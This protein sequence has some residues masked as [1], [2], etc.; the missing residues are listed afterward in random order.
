ML[1]NIQQRRMKHW[2]WL[3]IFQPSNVLHLHGIRNWRGRTFWSQRSVGLK[4]ALFVFVLNLFPTEPLH[5]SF[6]LF[7][8]S[9]I[10]EHTTQH[11]IRWTQEAKRFLFI[12][13]Q[14]GKRKIGISNFSLEFLFAP[15][16][17][18]SFSFLYFHHTLLYNAFP[19][20]VRVFFLAN[21]A[22][23]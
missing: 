12:H 11:K 15:F 22:L 17:Y 13:W 19:P 14:K 7:I 10:D 3:P 9:Y 6:W 4:N 20:T 16:P 1:N 18:I 23:I 21:C 5:S 8:W 2:W